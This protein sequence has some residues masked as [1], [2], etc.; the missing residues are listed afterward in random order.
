MQPFTLSFNAHAHNITTQKCLLRKSYE[1]FDTEIMKKLTKFQSWTKNNLFWRKCVLS[2]IRE[3]SWNLG[4]CQPKHTPH[5]INSPSQNILRPTPNGLIFCS[6]LWKHICSLRKGNNIYAPPHTKQCCFQMIIFTPKSPPITR[7]TL[8]CR[9]KGQKSDAV[10]EFLWRI[11]G[12]CC[13]NLSLT[14]ENIRVRLPT[15]PDLNL[16][17][18][19]NWSM[20]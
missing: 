6:F 12:G 11:E 5:P 15:R 8:L 13:T 10:S 4:P 17:P 16:K 1:S 19:G 18:L 20:E 3:V 14:V 7:T 2:G 9:G